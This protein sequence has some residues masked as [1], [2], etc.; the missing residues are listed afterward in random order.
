MLSADKEHDEGVQ[1]KLDEVLRGATEALPN[2]VGIWHARLDH[3][4]QNGQQKEAY[5]L[6]PKVKNL[7][8]NRYLIVLILRCFDD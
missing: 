4:L 1:K 3:L 5:T 2:S 6:F 8:N 7:A